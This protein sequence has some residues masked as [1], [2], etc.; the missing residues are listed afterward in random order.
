MERD[1]L[2]SIQNSALKILAHET[3][4]PTDEVVRIYESE[5]AKLTV[6]ARIQTFISALALRRARARL[7]GRRHLNAAR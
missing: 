2:Q 5:R 6:G 7:H 3:Q 4:T 1:N